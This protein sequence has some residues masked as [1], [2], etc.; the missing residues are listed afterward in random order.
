[1]AGGRRF[2]LLNTSLDGIYALYH[3]AACG[4]SFVIAVTTNSFLAG[5]ACFILGFPLLDFMFAILFVLALLG[6]TVAL[7]P[8]VALPLTAVL[9][10]GSM[11]TNSYL[12][13]G[14]ILAW[15]VRKTMKWQ[16]QPNGGEVPKPSVPENYG[17]KFA[18]KSARLGNN[19]DKVAGKNEMTQEKTK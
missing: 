18:P 12:F 11:V 19:A 15:L 14:R 8:V 10:F 5:I 16:S 7:P 17:A 3:L 2:F 4:F 13:G 6:V 1:M 9:L